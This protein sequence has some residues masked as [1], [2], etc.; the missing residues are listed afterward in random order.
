MITLGMWCI[1]KEK[2]ELLQNPSKTKNWHENVLINTEYQFHKL[3]CHLPIVSTMLA[4]FRVEYFFVERI[5]SLSC[6]T[7]IIKLYT[8][9]N[10]Y[11][12]LAC[13][14]LS[15]EQF[16]IVLALVQ[17]WQMKMIRFIKK[18]S[19]AKIKYYWWTDSCSLLFLVTYVESAVHLQNRK[20][21]T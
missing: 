13:G 11:G 16:W 2:P 17:K 10:I 12:N 6:L 7:P 19:T 8:N 20:R 5:M 21:K 1:S 15:K 3:D 14:D 4:N 9:N 18:T